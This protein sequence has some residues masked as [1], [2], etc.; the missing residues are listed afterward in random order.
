MCWCDVKDKT[1]LTWKSVVFDSNSRS[2]KKLYMSILNWNIRIIVRN[3][4]SIISKGN[5][6]SVIYL[7]YSELFH[8]YLWIIYEF[9]NYLWMISPVYRWNVYFN[10]CFWMRVEA[11]RMCKIICGSQTRQIC[12][13]ILI[14]MIILYSL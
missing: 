12:H 1:V 13:C 8:N 6:I 7:N 5:Y 10:K 3:E 14:E 9:I 2:C 11:N 4:S